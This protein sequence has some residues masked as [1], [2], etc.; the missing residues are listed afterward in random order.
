MNK[1]QIYQLLKE[2]FEEEEGSYLDTSPMDDLSKQDA[3]DPKF[4][5]KLLSE[6][7]GFEDDIFFYLQ[8]PAK[9]DIDFIENCINFQ[10]KYSTIKWEY[11]R[12]ASERIKNDSSVFIKYR[13]FKFSI[14]T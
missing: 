7:V 14:G 6:F 13:V 3:G 4:M 11:L 10:S 9:S 8:E 2:S 12:Y 1:E 5:L